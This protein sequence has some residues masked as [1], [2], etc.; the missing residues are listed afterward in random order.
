M[1]TPG[2]LTGITVVALEQAVSAP[3]CSRMLGDLGAR[4]IKIEHPD[5]GDFTRG[6]D[7]VVHG[8]AAHFAWLNRGKESLGL[9]VKDE[10]GQAVLHRL[11]ARSDV[12]LSNLGPGAMRRLGFDSASLGSRYPQLITLEVTGYGT[13][14]PMADKRAYD[15]LIQAEAG[16]CAITGWPG[17][18]AKP[19][20]PMAD[21]CTG[22]YAAL[23]IVS[24]LHARSR[25][26]RG[27]AASVSMFDSMVDLMGYA[28]THA[29]YTAADTPPVG[30]GSP[31]V[32][33][34]AAYPTA[35]GRLVVLGTTND[36]EWRRL[37]DLIGRPELGADPRYAR[38]PDR[39]ARRGELD[40][41]V[42]AWCSTRTLAD[43]QQLADGAGIG[44]ARFNTPVEVLEH[45]DLLARQRWREIGS[46]VGPVVSALP[47]P[48]IADWEPELGELPDVG[49]H[50]AG[51]L[52]ELGFDTADI[53]QWRDAGVIA[54]A[55]PIGGH[56]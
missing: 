21:V 29:R 34:Y 31:A 40:A 19:G 9:D 52:A 7:D 26:E 24:L 11:L 12:L 4:V 25:T 55:E 10:R 42:S 53:A 20:P 38:N 45:P 50:T 3:M 27:A 39:V 51:V 32:A 49:T 8:M 36:A 14:G 44:N 30:L 43:V 56:S 22:L 41:V 37:A 47:P 6:Y 5:G 17:R 2:P 16:A 18:P 15:L 33:P 35:D 13:G 23:T 46:P 54:V 28:L 48:V 1:T